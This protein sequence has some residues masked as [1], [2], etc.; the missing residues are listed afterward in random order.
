MKFRGKTSDNMDR[1]KSTA[2][3]KLRQGE[4]QK[5]EEEIGRKV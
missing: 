5:R 3:K 4:S 1:C 2:R